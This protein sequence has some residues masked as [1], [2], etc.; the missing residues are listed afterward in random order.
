M[1]NS[2]F[3]HETCCDKPC[4]ECGQGHCSY[5][6]MACNIEK[7]YCN[8]CKMFID[9]GTNWITYIVQCSDGTLY[10]GVSNNLKNRVKKHNSKTGGAK[11]T[12][13][14]QPVKLLKFFIQL[15]KSDAMKLEYKIKQLSR[16]DKFKL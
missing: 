10:T 6:A 14:R 1:F 12:R 5:M 15:S 11:Y 8:Y 9:A 13:T 4:I 2:G 16:E 7:H 3:E